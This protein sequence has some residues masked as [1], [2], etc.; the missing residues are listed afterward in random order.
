MEDLV[1]HFPLASV[2]AKAH[3]LVTCAYTCFICQKF[4]GCYKQNTRGIC[5]GL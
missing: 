1:E 4:R 2:F 5:L 3:E